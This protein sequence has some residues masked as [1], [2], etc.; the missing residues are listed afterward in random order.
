MKFFIAFGKDNTF[1][2][3]AKPVTNR[4]YAHSFLSEGRQPPAMDYQMAIEKPDA[5]SFIGTLT[6]VRKEFAEG[7]T[8]SF[9]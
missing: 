3:D 8:V 4:E 9:A 5:P 1:S 2:L 6:R 7:G